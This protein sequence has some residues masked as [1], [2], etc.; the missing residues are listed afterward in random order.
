MTVNLELHRAVWIE[1]RVTDKTT[2]Q[3]IAG[4]FVWYEP[5]LSNPFT[6]DLPEFNRSKGRRLMEDSQRYWTDADGRFRIAG[7]PGRAALVGVLALGGNYLRG[8]G[9][10]EI[11][12]PAKNGS[13]ETYQGRFSPQGQNAIKEIDP[14]A[15]ASEAI[16]DFVLV[17]GESVRL[18]VVDSERL[19]PL[20]G[21]WGLNIR[22]AGGTDPTCE[23]TPIAKCEPRARR[24]AATSGF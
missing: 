4:A 19:R 17:P 2:R 24:D 21:S 16:C 11:R 7:V 9:A 1:G 15:D 10:S 18:N 12:V 14:P 20:Y 23:W 5:F 3:P 6:F 8:V 22:A 13:Y